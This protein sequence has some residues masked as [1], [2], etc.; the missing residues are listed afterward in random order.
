MT[1]SRAL[2]AILL[3]AACARSADR[4][5]TR[6]QPSAS[7]AAAPTAVPSARPK[8]EAKPAPAPP[9]NVVLV[10][11]DAWRADMPWVGYPRDVAPRLAAFARRSTLYP[12]AYS[13]SSYTSKS[14]APILC[15]RYPSEMPRDGYYFTRWL[16]ENVFIG[17]LLQQAGQRTLAGN[18]HG[19]YM[20]ETGM[21]QGFTDFRLLPGTFLDLHGI[22]DITSDRLNALAK[23]MLSDPANVTQDG[24]HRFFAF[25]HFLDPHYQYYLHRDHPIW[26]Q[27]RRDLYDNEV[28][29]TDY[30]VG[31]LLDWIEKQPWGPRTAV[32]VTGDHGE[33]F[34]ERGQYRHGINLWESLIRVPLIIHVPGAPPRRIDLPRSHIDIAPSIGEL[35]G[36]PRYAGWSG[37]SLVAEVFGADPQ[38]R[39]VVSDM[40]R[41]DLMDRR[42]A[43]IDGDFKLISFSD[44][45]DFELFDVAHDPREEHELSREQPDRL[46]A[47]R[48]LYDELSAR[49]PTVP[50][51]GYVPLRGAPA[52]RRW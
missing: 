13:L 32:I 8:P 15:G 40:P 37:V 12:R 45:Y 29:Y 10:I 18:G 1:V 33:G 31:D 27:E 36:L 3:A 17:E 39:P 34:G 20:P 35:M 43:V 21:T 52:A 42:R 7:V 48:K 41:C 23:Q 28:H 25:F 9:Y 38:P 51:S 11:V 4:G 50:V 2:W 6:T 30:W 24:N 22:F 5:S 47:M 46:A 16:P 44:D 49:I 14:I 19:Y 26:G